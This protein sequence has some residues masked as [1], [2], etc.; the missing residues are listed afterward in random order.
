MTSFFLDII[1]NHEYYNHWALHIHLTYGVDPQSAL[2]RL[3][4]VL[5]PPLLPQTK[6]H[7][8]LFLDPPTLVQQK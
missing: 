4:A 6:V 2:E 5:L 8:T 1:R 3:Q 7:N